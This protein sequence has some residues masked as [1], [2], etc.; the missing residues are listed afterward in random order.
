MATMTTTIIHEIDEHNED[1]AEE[2]DLDATNPQVTF[3]PPLFLQR[4]MWILDVLRRESVV[5]VLDVGCGEGQ[6]LSVLAQPAPWLAPPPESV[7]PEQANH[8]EYSYKSDLPNLHARRIAGLD[9]SAHDLDFAVKGT[10]PPS[11][12]ANEDDP[13][14]YGVRVTRWE[15]LT[16]KVWKGGLQVINEEFVGVECI[17]CT[18]VIEHLPPDILPALA[19]TLLGVYHPERL[20]LTTPSYTFNSRFTWPNS[21]R[22]VRLRQAYADPTGRTN[23]IFRHDDHKFEWTPEE[24]AAWCR[25]AAGEWGYEIEELAGVGRPLEQDPWGRDDEL[26]DASLVVAFRRK[27]DGQQA[28]RAER[29]RSVLKALALPSEPHELLA[30]HQHKAHEKAGQQPTSDSI[31]LIG[32]MIKAKMESFREAFI[33]LEQMWFEQEVSALC[34]GWI[35]VMIWAVEEYDGLN[36]AKASDGKEWSIELVGGVKDPLVL[37]SSEGDSLDLIPADWIPGQDPED[38]SDEDDRPSTSP[39]SSTGADGDVSWNGSEIEEPDTTL[40]NEGEDHAAWAKEEW[41][42]ARGWGQTAQGWD[43]NKLKWGESQ[44]WGACEDEPSVLEI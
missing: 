44:E 31:K 32:D 9:I 20:L 12:S 7:F 4:R 36:L 18:E 6:L 40:T 13:Y 22:S 11:D 2:I 25:E 3:Y 5:N 39:P 16:A 14:T 15:D 42:Q 38:L 29:A 17:V 28:T 33:S 8:G 10:T 37:W 41:S 35:E 1:L 30:E 26:G 23:R 43:E 24:F 19:P 34:G 21:P 27:E